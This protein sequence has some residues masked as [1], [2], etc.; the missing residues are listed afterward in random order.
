[1]RRL[2]LG[3]ALASAPPEYGPALPQGQQQP[4][5][6]SRAAEPPRGR[7]AIGFGIAGVVLGTPMI[8]A[9]IP[10]AILTDA[11]II[12][13][14][15]LGVGIGLVALGTTGIVIGSKRNKAWRKW[16]S[17]NGSR[18]KL[19]PSGWANRGGFGFG[20]AGRF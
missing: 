8:Q 9:G 12:G 19:T 4:N 3:L 7:L 15:P 20:V 17:S 14:I 2:A 5:V 6:E 1:M 11:P 10:L 13:L 16:A 18:A